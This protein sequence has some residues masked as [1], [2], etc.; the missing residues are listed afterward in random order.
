MVRALSNAATG[1]YGIGHRPPAA[2]HEYAA[3]P[4]RVC[5]GGITGPGLGL[6]PPPEL[7][8][9]IGMWPQELLLNNDV[10][11]VLVYIIF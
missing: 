4:P 9:S 10:W 6:A 2:A 5:V 11:K 7:C 8:L 1:R 3:Q